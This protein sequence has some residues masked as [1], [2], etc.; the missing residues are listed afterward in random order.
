L[1]SLENLWKRL[2]GPSPLQQC[3]PRPP[4]ADQPSAALKQPGVEVGPA[5][6]PIHFNDA[7]APGRC[8]TAPLTVSPPSRSTHHFSP[9]S[10]SL[11]PTCLRP[12]LSPRCRDRREKPSPFNHCHLARLYL[13]SAR[14]CALPSMSHRRQA[15]LKLPHRAPFLLESSCASP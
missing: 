14:P 8:P 2:Q 4:R 3:S 7:R 5:H 11:A 9:C 1:A 12:P 10:T 13:S 6:W 15:R